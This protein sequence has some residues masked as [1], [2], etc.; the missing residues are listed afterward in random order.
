MIYKSYLV[1][2]N[3]EILKNN[4][5][6]LYGENLGL[7]N[8]LKSQ[9]KKKFSKSEFVNFNQEDVLKNEEEFFR[10]LLNI[11]LFNE[12]KVFF[13][14]QV[15][16]KILE[17]LK[18]IEPKI[19]S[20]KIFLFSELLDKKSKIRVYFEKSNN[21]GILPC[22]ADNEI[23]IKKIITNKLKE[24][25]GVSAENI[26]LIIDS[27]GLDRVKLENELSKIQTY[28]NNKIIEKV[29]LET[30]L[31]LKSNDDFNLLKDAAI[32]GN[33]VKTNKLLGDTVL[34]PEKNILYLNII[35]QRLNKLCEL[36]DLSK[37]TNI[38]IELTNLKPPIF[39]KDKPIFISQIKRWN[40]KKIREILNKCYNLEITIK[41]NSIVNKNTLLKKLLLDIC[42]QAN[43][44]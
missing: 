27:C 12:R 3:I 19:D 42:E 39:W 30:L 43:P 11:S 5:L 6:L 7:K 34:D 40:K 18:K 21:L 8:D 20:Q 29:K 37:N 31:N 9:I 44:S 1:E 33:K 38:D 41:S 24:F 25:K 22:Y 17:L 35:N 2:Q 32:Q 15:N 28:F 16:D 13:I 4:I 23:T 26:N 14:N 10:E 36:I